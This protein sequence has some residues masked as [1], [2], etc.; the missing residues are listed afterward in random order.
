MLHLSAL[1]NVN[2]TLELSDGTLQALWSIYQEGALLFCAVLSYAIR[3]TW[4]TLSPNTFTI[5]ITNE[6]M[7]Y[8]CVGLDH[9]II[10][11]SFKLITDSLHYHRNQIYEYSPLHV[12]IQTYIRQ[13]VRNSKYCNYSTTSLNT[14][15]QYLLV[16]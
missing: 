2:E 11:M 9:L 5:L 1:N 14:I 13:Y 16:D 10:N 4:M 8:L 6:H 3:A 15:I 7:W 12:K